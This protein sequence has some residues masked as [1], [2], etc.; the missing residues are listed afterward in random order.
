MLTK[1]KY[2]ILFYSFDI[3]KIYSH[4]LV[5]V[6]SW[7]VDD[8]SLMHRSTDQSLARLAATGVDNECM[9]VN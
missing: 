2:P 9:D 6:C 5:V 8:S 3:D 7:G 4:S 1:S